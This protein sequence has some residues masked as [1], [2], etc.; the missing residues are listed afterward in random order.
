MK[1]STK[2]TKSKTKKS[3][4]SHTTGRGTA[5]KTKS[6]STN[7]RGN[8]GGSMM[9]TK[10]TTQSKAG[11]KNIV[12][13]VKNGGKVSGYKLS[14]GSTVNKTRGVALAKK[15]EINGVGVA[16]R[17]GSEY[18]KTMPGQKKKGNLLTLPTVT[19]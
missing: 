11:A 7:S 16:S 13:L 3:T 17:N 9:S 6:T 15:G 12:G 5:N 1:K 2:T 14:D 8:S 4:S 19:N 18:L 10:S